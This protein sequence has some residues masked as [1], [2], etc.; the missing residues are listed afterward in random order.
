MCVAKS[1]LG[2]INLYIIFC[3]YCL[4]DHF[5][6]HTILL[7]AYIDTICELSMHITFYFLFLS[8]W[9]LEKVE[10]EAGPEHPRIKIVPED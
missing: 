3:F 4:T 2:E 7:M 6:I 9:V 10:L 5:H 1:A 8:R